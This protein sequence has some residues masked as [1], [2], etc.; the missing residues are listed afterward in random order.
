MPA[1][2]LEGITIEIQGTSKG[3]GFTGAMKKHNFHG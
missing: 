1:S 2:V 3:K